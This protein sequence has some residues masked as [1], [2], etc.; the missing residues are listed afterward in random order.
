M[1]KFLVTIT[2]VILGLSLVACST[3]AGSSSSFTSSASAITSSNPTVSAATAKPTQDRSGLS[4]TPPETVETIVVLAPSIAE[5][6]NG[7]GAEDRI[8]GIDTESVRLEIPTPENVIVFDTVTPNIEEIAS[9]NPDLVLASNL[10]GAG[11][12]NLFTQLTSMGICVAIIPT[13][14]SIAGIEEDIEFIASLLNTQNA[15]ET[16]VNN[17]QQ[18]IDSIATIAQTIPDDERKTVYFEISENPSYSFGSDV[19]LN[20]LIETLGAKNVFVDQSGWL[21]VEPESAIAADP[22]VILTNVNYIDNPVDEILNR[23]GW[24]NVTAVK[25]KEVYS[26]NNQTSSL[27]NQNVVLALEEMAKLIYPEYYK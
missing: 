16:M 12:A 20:E 4:I 6:V 3:G 5:I 26:V 17:M 7:L 25:N 2:S 13:S 10:S 19:F 27:P 8:V 14:T 21:L 22:D 18:K 9:L 1:K 11:G 15:G 24:G 23:T